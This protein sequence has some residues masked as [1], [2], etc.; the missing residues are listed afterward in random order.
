MLLVS[1]FDKFC[2]STS[3]R[4]LLASCIIWRSEWSPF[5]CLKLCFARSKE[6]SQQASVRT[7]MS[8]QRVL[9]L[10]LWLETKKEKTPSKCSA[11]SV[12]KIGKKVDWFEV[13]YT[14]LSL[15][16]ESSHREI[17]ATPTKPERIMTGIA[18]YPRKC[19]I[20]DSR[21]LIVYVSPY[22]QPSTPCMSGSL[23]AIPL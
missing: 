3:P 18:L 10:V 9:G 17:A 2:L 13:N 1:M 20:K 19:Q 5:F 15:P 12:N 8:R 7:T 11:F 4:L 16:S 21:L 14:S 23:C 6:S 22:C